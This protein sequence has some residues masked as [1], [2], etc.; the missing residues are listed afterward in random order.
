MSDRCRKALVMDDTLATR[1]KLNRDHAG[2]IH[3]ARGRAE[4]PDQSVR[5]LDGD[6]RQFDTDIPDRHAWEVP[7]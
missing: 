4:L 7:Q 6:R 5:W 2:P 1:C 3:I